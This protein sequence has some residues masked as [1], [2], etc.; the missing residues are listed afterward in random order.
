M[1]TDLYLIQ[2]HGGC[3]DGYRQSVN[4]ILWD[5]RLKMPG[6]LPC[7]KSNPSPPRTALY[8][9]RRTSIRV[10][11]GWPTMV[12]DYDFVGMRVGVVS[13]AIARL[14]QWKNRLVQ[15]LL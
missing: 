15:S 14:V 13:A 4:Y 2:L 7:P 8:E 11:S 6:T 12:L 5:T 3:F 1:M 10:L 9:L